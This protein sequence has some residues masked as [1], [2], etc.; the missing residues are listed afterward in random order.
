MLVGDMAGER[1]AAVGNWCSDPPFLNVRRM[2]RARTRFLYGT[3]ILAPVGVISNGRISSDDSCT[4]AQRLQNYRHCICKCN[5]LSSSRYSYIVL[6]GISAAMGEEESGSQQDL[7]GQNKGVED[8]MLVRWDNVLIE[9]T[10][11]VR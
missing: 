6:V 11:R 5:C 10:G 8:V 7:R 1:D 2:I 9:L 4:E 3:V